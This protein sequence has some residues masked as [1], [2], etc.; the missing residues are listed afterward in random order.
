MDIL[1]FT[2]LSHLLTILSHF[3]YEIQ[4]KLSTFLF[5]KHFIEKAMP[6]KQK[7]RLKRGFCDYLYPKKILFYLNN[8]VINISLRTFENKILAFFLAH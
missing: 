3:T 4:A 8:R 2:T 5:T 6:P 1:L 7:P